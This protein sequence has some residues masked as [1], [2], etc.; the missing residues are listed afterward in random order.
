MIHLDLAAATA[1]VKIHS[2]LASLQSAAVRLAERAY[3]RDWPFWTQ[4]LSWAVAS[5][6]HALRRALVRR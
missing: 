3:A 6:V 1:V 2:G 4:R 5:G